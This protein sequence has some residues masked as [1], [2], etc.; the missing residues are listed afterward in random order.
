VDIAFLDA[1]VLFSTA[2]HTDSRLR[3]LWRLRDAELITSEY[4]IEEAR[5]NLDSPEARDRL[6]DLVR[7]TRIVP[8]AAE[9]PLP[10]GIELPEKDRPILVAA[11]AA[12]ATH[13]ITGD[14]THFGRYHGRSVGGVV[15]LTL[16]DFLR[17]RR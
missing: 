3:E 5:R 6:D 1:N 13:L 9:L 11:M 10:K 4:A 7:A 14:V 2:Y 17:K 15:I 12:R 16:A 8:S